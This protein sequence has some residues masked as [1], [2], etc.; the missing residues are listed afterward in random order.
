MIADFND[1]SLWVY[2]IVEDICQQ[3]QSYVR[4][5]GPAPTTGSD[6]ELLA[7][8][9]IGEC[10]GHDMETEVLSFWSTH[11][12]LF[13]ILPSQSRF[14]RRR[15]NLMPLCNL[16]RRAILQLLDVAQQR[17]CVIDSLPVPVVA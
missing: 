8:A 16:V 11:R 12:D 5:P 9:I 13:P 3:L 7:M 10:R 14:N 4:R 2:Y 6:S 17:S 15:R 1:F